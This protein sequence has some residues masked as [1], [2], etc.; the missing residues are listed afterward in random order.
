MNVKVVARHRTAPN[1]QT[2]NQ[3]LAARGGAAGEIDGI[4][5]NADEEGHDEDKDEDNGE[6]PRKHCVIDLP[7]PVCLAFFCR[8]PK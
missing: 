7:H 6:R 3:W 8:Y 2:F 1:I 5:S 4:G